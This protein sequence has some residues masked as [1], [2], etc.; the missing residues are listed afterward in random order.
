MATLTGSAGNAPQRF[1][2]LSGIR[3]SGSGFEMDGMFRAHTSRD[4]RRDREGRVNAP[5]DRVF[6]PPEETELAN[7]ETEHPVRGPTSKLA[8]DWAPS[9]HRSRRFS[10]GFV[11]TRGA[12]VG[13]RGPRDA[14]NRDEN[15]RVPGIAPF[16]PFPLPSAPARSRFLPR[17]YNK[18][19]SFWL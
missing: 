6:P 5:P 2:S 13:S 18:L 19:T 9:Q 10:S 12:M 15:P 4:D 1:A 14:P 17:D 3:R 8:A 7:L 11:A 16:L